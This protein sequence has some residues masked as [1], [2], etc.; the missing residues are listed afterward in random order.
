MAETVST[1][2]LKVARVLF[3]FIEKEVLPGTGVA[4][5]AFWAGF[6]KLT[7]DLAPKNRALLARRDDLQLQID[8]WHRARRG[9][10][11]DREAYES[12]L[13]NIG[14]LE[15]EGADFSVTTPDVD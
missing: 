9:K 8:E 15:A 5:D 12:F 10:P 11:F 3:D 14:Y 13:R 6:A 7:E 1:H 4:S 2:G